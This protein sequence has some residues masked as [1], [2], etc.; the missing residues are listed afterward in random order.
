M[1]TQAINA[2]A[3]ANEENNVAFAN[4]TTANTTLA[5]QVQ[6]LETSL[7]ALRAENARI[8][9]ARG[10]RG[11]NGGR[12]AE[13]GRGRNGRRINNS[14]HYCHTHGR[15]R[16]PAHTSTTCNHPGEN[17]DVDATFEDQRGGSTRW[18]ED[19]V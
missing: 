17:H 19:Q 1:Q 18:I 5:T 3:Q 10:G 16:N 9:G 12:G 6:A 4:M 13:G 14:T 2:L 15:T 8:I 11:R 7:R